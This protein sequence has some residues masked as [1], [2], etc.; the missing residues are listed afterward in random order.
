MKKIINSA[1]GLEKRKYAREE[2]ERILTE[3]KNKFV[4]ETEI[5]KNAISELK[6]ENERLSSEL[7]GFK[8]KNAVIEAAIKDSKEKALEI[9]R[10]ADLRYS[11]VI[12]KLKAFSD[13]W[14]VYFDYLREKYPLYSVVKQ[15][16]ELKDKMTELLN[17]G[18]D[19][20]TVDVLEFELNGITNGANRA[21]F[22]PKEKIREYVAAT[23]DNGFD[24]NEVLNPGQLRLEDLCKE[25]GLTE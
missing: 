18:D 24:L 20:K 21:P 9:E 16:A 15:S 13:K 1:Y 25:L 7:D 12:E 5:L 14:R 4:A 8:E 3:E 11:L 17:A 19:K 22:D 23:E 10:K 6:N 2:V